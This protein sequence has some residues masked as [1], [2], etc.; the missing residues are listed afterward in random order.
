METRDGK[1]AG[2]GRNG[3]RRRREAYKIE[4]STTENIDTRTIRVVYFAFTY[5]AFL[6]EL[7]LGASRARSRNVSA[8]REKE[9]FTRGG[10][11]EIVTRVTTLESISD[12]D[13]YEPACQQ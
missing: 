3:G 11:N 13:A 10:R 5:V 2:R 8:R 9:R 4:R 1:L 12:V 6:L 7:Y